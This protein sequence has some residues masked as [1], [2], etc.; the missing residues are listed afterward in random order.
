MKSWFMIAAVALVPVAAATVG[1]YQDET[2][3]IKSVMGKLHKGS[4]AQSKVLDQQSKAGSPNW[5]E[6]KKTTKDFV[7]LGASL[8]KNDPPRGDKAS[9]KKLADNYFQNA[10]ALDDAAGDKDLTALQ[11]AQKKMGGSCKSCHTAHREEK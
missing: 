4:K 5:D 2:P 10:K 8:S 1:A 11:A 7:I 3:S 6:I 9:W